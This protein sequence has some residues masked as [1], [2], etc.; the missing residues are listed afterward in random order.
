V[1]GRNIG[2]IGNGMQC[3]WEWILAYRIPTSLSASG[4]SLGLLHE[5]AQASMVR[6]AKSKIAQSVARLRPLARQLR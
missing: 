2:T 3:L 4:S 6:D 5:S 1:A